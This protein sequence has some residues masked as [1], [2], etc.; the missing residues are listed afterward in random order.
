MVLPTCFVFPRKLSP[1]VS[2]EHE[3]QTLLFFFCGSGS[4]SGSGRGSGSGSGR[5]SC[6]YVPA[7]SSFSFASSWRV[8]RRYTGENRISIHNSPCHADTHKTYMWKGPL[9]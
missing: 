4:G 8:E 1:R 5:S 7:H 2:G 6:L 3:L 9:A